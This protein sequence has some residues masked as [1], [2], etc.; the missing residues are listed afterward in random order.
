MNRCVTLCSVWAICFAMMI[1][2]EGCKVQKGIMHLD[3]D[4]FETAIRGI[5]VRC[6]NG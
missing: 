6:A 1:S 2:L 5:S 3:V 4:E